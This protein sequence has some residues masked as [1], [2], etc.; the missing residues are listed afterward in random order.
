M[1]E[2][3]QVGRGIIVSVISVTTIYVGRELEYER[4]AKIFEDV[5]ISWWRNFFLAVFMHL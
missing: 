4:N 5:H 2:Q 3:V 1:K